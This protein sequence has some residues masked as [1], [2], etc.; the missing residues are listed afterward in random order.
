LHL[1]A[2]LLALLLA[3]FDGMIPQLAPFSGALLFGFFFL[4]TWMACLE[5]LRRN[6]LWW[7]GLIG[8]LGGLAYLA[9]DRVLPLLAVFIGVSTLRAFWGWLVAQGGEESGTTLWVRRNHGF[10]LLL[11]VSVFGAMAG[12]RLVEAHRQ[13]GQPWISHVDQVRWLE[14][15]EEAE[16]WLT[17][18]EIAEKAAASWSWASYRLDHEPEAIWQRWQTGLVEVLRRLWQQGGGL[19]AGEGLALLGLL[20]AVRL[21][22][23]KAS[24]AWQRLHPETAST[25]LFFVLA[26]WVYVT[27]AAWDAAVGMLDHLPALTAPVAFGLLS[28]GEGVLCRARRRDAPL[29]IARTYLVVLW[30]LV[31]LGAA[32]V[33]LKFSP[34]LTL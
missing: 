13:F 6:S 3:A 10:G 11:L 19:L 28:G 31:F 27:I 30:L 4:F 12:P 18:S 9:E 1:P 25:V 15:R 29:W 7:Y 16:A 34:A 8:G 26:V 2:T 24:H 21:G 32:R 23:P 22:A 20:I 17:Q 14:N 33:W 5:A